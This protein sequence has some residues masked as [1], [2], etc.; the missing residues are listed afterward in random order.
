MNWIANH[1]VDDDRG[2]AYP[3]ALINK[4]NYLSR[5]QMMSEEAATYHVETF[6]CEGKRERITGDSGVSILVQ[7]RRR[8]VK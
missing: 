5:L 7:V 3:E 1:I 8:T 4:L 2:A 6:V